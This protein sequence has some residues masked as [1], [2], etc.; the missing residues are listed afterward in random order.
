[1]LFVGLYFLGFMITVTTG[2]PI[3]IYLAMVVMFGMV[4]ALQLYARRRS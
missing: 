1:M 3:G 4:I 2:N